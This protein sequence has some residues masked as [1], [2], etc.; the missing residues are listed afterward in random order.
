MLRPSRALPS[1]EEPR[2]LH[3]P[4]E[5]GLGD[6]RA[7]YRAVREGREA[8]VRR[9][10]HP[11]GAE[12]LDGSTR[13]RCDLLERL[14]AIELLIHH[15]DADAALAGQLL[16]HVDLARARRAELEEE[17][18]DLDLLQDGEERSVVAGEGRPL[19]ARPVAAADVQAEPLRGEAGHHAIDELGR[20]GELAPGITLLAE[21]PA[22]EAAR[23]LCSR[24]HHLG[25]HGLVELH[26]RGPC[27]KEEMQLLAEYP[28]DVLRQVLP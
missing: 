9:Q 8:A 23:A 6:G 1:S 11:F 2:R 22:H 16:Q 15:T 19:V 5:L 24:E 20:E 14:D 13:P 25:E 17:R 3:D 18:A 26:E 4:A 7:R 28:H 12:Y 21:R 10:E 27:G